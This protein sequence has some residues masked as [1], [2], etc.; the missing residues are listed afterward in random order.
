MILH[1]DRFWARA[2][3]ATTLGVAQ[4]TPYSISC[5]LELNSAVFFFLTTNQP[6]I[7]SAM[8]YQPNMA[9]F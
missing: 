7:L 5:S 8:V 9:W 2:T 6:T 1:R 3:R 4:R